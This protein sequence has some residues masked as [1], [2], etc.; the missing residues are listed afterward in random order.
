MSNLVE[1]HGSKTLKPLI[2]RDKDQIE[3][4]KNKSVTLSK[5]IIIVST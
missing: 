4:L 2:V 5:I 1:P 3:E